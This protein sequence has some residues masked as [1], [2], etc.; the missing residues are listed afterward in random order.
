[1]LGEVG[2]NECGPGASLS[3]GEGKTIDIATKKSCA[4]RT[5]KQGSGQSGLLENR[6]GRR[7]SYS[8]AKT[9]VREKGSDILRGS[10]LTKEE[11]LAGAG[12]ERHCHGFGGGSRRGARGLPTCRTWET[13][14][15]KEGRRGQMAHKGGNWGERLK[16]PTPLGYVKGSAD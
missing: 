3:V 14:R 9:R 8:N 13:Y 11:T 6:V 16:E 10:Y 12:D 4:S 1:M 2:G 5:R 7:P 15:A